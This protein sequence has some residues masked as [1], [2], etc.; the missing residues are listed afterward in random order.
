MP[1]LVTS[2]ADSPFAG[3]ILTKRSS[4][5]GEG[6][7]DGAMFSAPTTLI[8]L[9]AAL[10]ETWLSSL[11]VAR[12]H[13][14]RPPRHAADASGVGVA[15]GAEAERGTE[16]ILNHHE[17]HRES[18]EDHDQ[19]RGDCDLGVGHAPPDD[20]PSIGAVP[21]ESLPEG[22]ATSLA[23]GF[24]GAFALNVR[25]EPVFFG[26]WKV[27]LT[28]VPSNVAVQF[29]VPPAEVVLQCPPEPPDA[30]VVAVP[31]ARPWG[32]TCKHKSFKLS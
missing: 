9:V 15:V 19:R 27:P 21:P 13:R 30:V 4:E 12:L 18:E 6:P 24:A 20:V 17:A 7:L 16:H 23:G 10:D 3:R 32:R 1:P 14:R 28:R 11:I 22:A 31:E 29:T 5:S 25:C 2:C 8:G 26:S